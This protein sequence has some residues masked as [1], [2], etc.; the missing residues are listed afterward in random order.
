VWL[1]FD[2]INYRAEVWLNGAKVAEKDR[3]AGMFQRFRF[4]VMRMRGPVATPLL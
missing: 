1:N 4:D 3:M 2:C